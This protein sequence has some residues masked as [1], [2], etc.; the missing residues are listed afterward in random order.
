MIRSDPLQLSIPIRRSPPVGGIAERGPDQPTQRFTASTCR[1][2]HAITITGTIHGLHLDLEPTTLNDHTEYQALRDGTP[3]YDLWPDR[4]A[5][6][7]HLEEIQA[8]ERVPR[9]ARHTC[10]T[11]YGTDP[12]PEP[13]AQPS[14]TT[15][16]TPPF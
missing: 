5:R 15:S 10:G 4:K 12:R 3:T 16:N 2:C 1:K 11:T 14:S 9:H 6:R 7:R 8:P 13:P